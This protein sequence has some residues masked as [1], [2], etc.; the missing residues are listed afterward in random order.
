MLFTY[1]I[2]IQRELVSLLYKMTFKKCLNLRLVSENMLNKWSSWVYASAT[3]RKLR[4]L[5]NIFDRWICWK[6]SC[7]DFVCHVCNSSQSQL[8]KI[9]CHICAECFHLN[10]L[11]EISRKEPHQVG[12]LQM[13][14]RNKFACLRCFRKWKSEQREKERRMLRSQVELSNPIEISS[15]ILR[16]NRNRMN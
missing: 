14:T 11:L 3:I 13:E 8:P 12:L 1:I 7:E 4:S 15:H 16:L 9:S 10:C 6:K 2:I 5:L